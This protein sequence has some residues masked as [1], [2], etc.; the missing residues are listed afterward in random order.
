MEVG[1]TILCVKNC[2]VADYA[3]KS[4]NCNP[5]ATSKVYIDPSI[6]KAKDLLHW[7]FNLDDDTRSE[8]K[9][10]SKGVSLESNPTTNDVYDEKFLKGTEK[11]APK[12]IDEYMVC[13]KEVTQQKTGVENPPVEQEMNA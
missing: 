5:S 13:K 12:D 3:C 2:Q 9:S 11:P 8:F 7:Y 10:L 1:S 6:E 4:L